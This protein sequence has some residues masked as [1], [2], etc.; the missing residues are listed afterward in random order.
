MH[1]NKQ[2]LT[3]HDLAEIRKCL[4]YDWRLQ[5]CLTHRDLT[6]RNVTEVF[7]L[8]TRNSDWTTK[9]FGSIARTLRKQGQKEL[10]S[11]CL[12]RIRLC[13]SIQLDAVA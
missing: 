8:R 12:H 7:Y 10:A 4:P 2:Q 9:V 13:R 5:I 11:K 1:N 3:Q 6:A